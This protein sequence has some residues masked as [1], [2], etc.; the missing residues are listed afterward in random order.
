VLYVLLARDLHLSAGVIGVITAT[1]ALGGLLGAS[2]AA[3][4]ARRFGQGPTIWLSA[5]SCAPFGFVAPFVQ[6]NWSLALL[7]LAQML[8]WASAVVYNITQVSFRQG[9]CP[10]ALLGRMNATIRFLVW[11]TMPIGGLIGGAIGS[12]FGVRTALLVAAVGGSVAF[13]PVFLS[14]LRT[15]REL[16]SYVEPVS[17]SEMASPH[18][19]SDA[20]A[21]G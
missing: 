4:A 11:G 9:L 10:P 2:I 15:Q 21:L 19:E 1:S 6:R 18:L 20:P 12:A 14:P 7:A 16:P 3:R 8:W 17:P 13:V 5:L